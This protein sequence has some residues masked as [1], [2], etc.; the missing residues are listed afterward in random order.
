MEM[1]FEASDGIKLR[2]WV[3]FLLFAIFVMSYV[4]RSLIP[5]A[6]PFIAREFHI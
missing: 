1:K 2:W 6:I 4:D 5:L 3:C